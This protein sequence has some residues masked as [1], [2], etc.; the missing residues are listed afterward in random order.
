MGDG[1]EKRKLVATENGKASTYALSSVAERGSLFI[2]PRDMVYAG[3]VISESSGPG[4]LDVNPV[5][6]KALNNMRAAGKDE[7]VYLP[8]P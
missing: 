2:E 5:K 7:K 3:M 4:D 1:L 8:P 6:A